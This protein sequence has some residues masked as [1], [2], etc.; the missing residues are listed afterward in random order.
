MIISRRKR[1]LEMEQK[2]FSLVSQVLSFRHTNLLDIR[3]KLAKMEQ[4]QPLKSLKGS[5]SKTS[6]CLHTQY[7]DVHV[8]LVPWYLTD[9]TENEHWNRSFFFLTFCC[10]ISPISGSIL[11]YCIME[12][13]KKK[14]GKNKYK[15]RI[16]SPKNHENFNH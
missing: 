14:S 11:H 4:T 3:Y 15:L 12:N 7:W 16:I 10:I 1:A 6:P 8:N 5:S 2:T 13:L 9:C